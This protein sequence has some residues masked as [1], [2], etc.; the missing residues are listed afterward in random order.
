MCVDLK[1]RWNESLLFWQVGRSPEKLPTINRYAWGKVWFPQRSVFKSERLRKRLDS[2][3]RVLKAD[4]SEKSLILEH[5]WEKKFKKPLEINYTWIVKGF[6]LIDVTCW[7]RCQ[8]GWWRRSQGRLSNISSKDLDSLCVGAFPH[9]CLDMTNGAEAK[10]LLA[11][12]S[13]DFAHL[14]DTSSYR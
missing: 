12:L 13:F 5:N 8:G 3:C 11:K 6:G 9:P 4:R 14:I 7:Q 10:T 2:Q 1:K